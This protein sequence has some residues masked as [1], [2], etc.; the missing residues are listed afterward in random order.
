MGRVVSSLDADGNRSSAGR[1]ALTVGVP[2]VVAFVAPGVDVATLDFARFGPA[3]RRHP[4]LR[5]G[6]NANV[7]Q[8]LGPSRLRVQDVGARR[9]GR[10]ARVRLGQRRDGR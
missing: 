7:V 5:E 3:L 8:V 9:R 2:N 10:D 4:D 6:A 1:Y